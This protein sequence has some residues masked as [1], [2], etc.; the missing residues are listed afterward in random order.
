MKR[1]SHP[2]LYLLVL[3]GVGF[4]FLASFG[5]IL[6][7][8]A[9]GANLHWAEKL[10]FGVC[11]QL[12]DRTY[13]LGETMMAVNTRCLGIFFGIAAGWLLIP[14]IGAHTAGKR[15]PVML[16]LLALSLQV[17]DYLGNLAEIWQ[18]TNHSRAILGT[19]FGAAISL[20]LSDLFIKHKN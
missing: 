8:E 16:L 12:P 4:V 18:N 3:A 13:H 9:S 20:S 17:V 7:G 10:F 14:G 6:W 15:W 1:L 5:E 19:L 11:H 2:F